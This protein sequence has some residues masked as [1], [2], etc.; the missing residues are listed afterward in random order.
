[1]IHGLFIQ[2]KVIAD[3]FGAGA[4]VGADNEL[5]LNDALKPT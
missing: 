4:V 3:L 1:M 5:P 2:N